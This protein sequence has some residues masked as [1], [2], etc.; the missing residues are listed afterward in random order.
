M[1]LETDLFHS[2]D[3]VRRRFRVSLP[4]PCKGLMRNEL[5]I[6]VTNARLEKLI[7]LG[8]ADILLPYST[9][10]AKEIIRQK[11]RCR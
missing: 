9:D 6:L 4:C 8:D 10:I 2:V 1:K 11:L 7:R 5:V 3:H